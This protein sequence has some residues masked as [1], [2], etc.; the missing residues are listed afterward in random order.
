MLQQATLYLCYKWEGGRLV[1]MISWI[2]DNI[3]IGQTDLVLKLKSELMMQFEC[4]DCGALT[5]Y[6]GNKIKYVG[7]DAIRMIRLF[8]QQVTR[9]NLS[10]EKDVTIRQQLQEQC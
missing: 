6:I 8:R 7:K 1:I 9:M 10:L 4:A 2:V 5:E 3:I